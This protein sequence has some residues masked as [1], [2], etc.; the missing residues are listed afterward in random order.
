MAKDIQLLLAKQ[1]ILENLE[2]IQASLNRCVQEGMIDL[3]DDYYNEI[4]GLMEDAR[5][6]DNW[7]EMMEAI[8]RAKTLEIDIA[9]WLS[10]HGRTTVSFNWPKNPKS[11]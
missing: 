2:A 7:D 6:L 4:L 3:D 1:V 10:R 9:S 5:T 11:I 8:V